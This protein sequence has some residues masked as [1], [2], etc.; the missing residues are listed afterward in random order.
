MGSSTSGFQMLTREPEPS[1][2][3]LPL[4]PS[5]NKAL[6]HTEPIQTSITDTGRQTLEPGAL[7]RQRAA[8]SPYGAGE[9]GRMGSPATSP[10]PVRSRPPLRAF[11]SAPARRFLARRRA[12]S[13]G[14]KD[15]GRRSGGG[16]AALPL[17]QPRPP[18]ALEDRNWALGS[19]PAR[20]GA[21]RSAPER[22]LL[23][24]TTRPEEPFAARARGPPGS[25][26]APEGRLLLPSRTR[27]AFYIT[28]RKRRRHRRP[29][30]WRGRGERGPFAAALDLSLSTRRTLLAAAAAPARAVGGRAPG[31]AHHGPRDER[32]LLLQCP[33][34]F[35]APVMNGLPAPPG[36]PA[37][38]GGWNE[39]CEHHA[40]STARELARKYLLFVSENPQHEVLAAENFSLQFADL[41]QQYFRNEVKDGFAMNRFRILPFSRVRDYRETGRKQPGGSLG[42]V[43]AKAEVELAD[44]AA[45]APETHPRGL[46]KAWSSED[47]AGTASPLAVRRPFS[48]DRL[49]RSWRSF[50]RRRSLEP[51][52]G[53]G[54]I[55]DSVSKPGLARKVF[56]WALSQDPSSQI[57]KEGSL[58][59]WMVT[60]ATMDSG[61]CW[62]RCR[63]V[64]RRAG[65]LDNDDYILEVFDPP[66]VSEG[67]RS[68]RPVSVSQWLVVVL[69]ALGKLLALLKHNCALFPVSRICL[70]LHFH[71]SSWQ[72]PLR[73]AVLPR[74]F[75]CF[76][77]HTIIF[78]ES[79][80]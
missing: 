46:T 64:L 78:P 67:S 63:L 79:Y 80:C 45:R 43:V 2:A 56:P 5:S 36:D 1:A 60:E 17:T 19:F 21:S 32:R 11:S 58:K 49:R 37:H 73:W 41:F 35:P 25:P 39:F 22:Q 51:A 71:S 28:A 14:G 6:P 4:R 44:Q 76:L 52:P 38:P 7:C 29:G 10:T 59:Y 77:R 42:G 55:L 24:P 50:F 9:Q 18:S 23:P 3:A 48:L 68:R 75:V 74:G 57:Q 13:E 20:P 8:L 33:Q 65:A 30:A 40:I 70:F 62:Q 26:A 72:E 66:K 15:A 27:A 61:A 53:G 47:L 31:K 12:A 34:M 54:E 16:S 69:V